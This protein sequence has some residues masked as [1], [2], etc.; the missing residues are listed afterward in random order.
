MCVN[1][2]RGETVIARRSRS[3]LCIGND[4]IALNFRCSLLKK[5]GWVAL[6]SGSG[7]SGVL[8]FQSASVDVVVLDLNGDGSEIALIAS[9]LKR[10]RPVP[11]VVLVADP[12]TLNPD[13]TN[14]AAAVIAKAR[15]K[16]RLV[17][18][19]EELVPEA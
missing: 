12:V 14:Q 19:L 16:E 8:Q 2:A 15:E 10:I 3:V 18:L 7:H 13:A 9:A 6:S 17:A 4:P 11:I 1:Q 5:H